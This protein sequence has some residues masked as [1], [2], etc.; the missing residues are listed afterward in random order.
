VDPQFA[1][2]NQLTERLQQE[3]ASRQFSSFAQRDLYRTL[4]SGW[5]SHFLE[6]EERSAS[7]FGIEERHP[8][9]DRRIV[10]FALA[11]PEEQRWRRDQ[12]KYLLRR[13]LAGLLPEV[14]RIRRTKADFSHAFAEALKTLGGESLFNS[15]A[16]ASMGWVDGAWVRRMY[17]QMAQLY[18]LGDGGYTRHVWPLWMIFGIELWFKTLFLKQE[19]ITKG[20]SHSGGSQVIA[21]AY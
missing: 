3:Q 18:A 15:L 12:P 19:N 1:R 17:Q 9:N 8:L 16:I 10:E 14:V 2:R 4:T 21:L 7:W 20:A 6:M 5:Q 11:L 13:A